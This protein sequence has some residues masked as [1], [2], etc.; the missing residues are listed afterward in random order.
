[1]ELDVL[2]QK[3]NEHRGEIEAPFVFCLWKNPDLYDD[4]KF[5]NEKEDDIIRNPDA[6]FY[7]N[8]GRALYKAGYRNF[9]HIAV[10]TFLQDKE[11]IKKQFDSYGGFKEVEEFKGLVS[12]ENVNAYFDKVARLNILDEMCKMM[13]SSFDKLEKFD[14]MTSQQIYDYFEYKLNDISITATHDVEEESLVI[15][16]AFIEECNSGDTVGISYGKQCPLLNYLTL[17]VPL[18]E[19]YM[20]AGHSGAGKSSFAFENMAIPMAQDGIK[21]AIVSNEMRSKDY[22]VMLLAHILT[23]DLNYWGLTRKQIKIGH[24]TDEQKIMIAKAQK[25]SKEKYSNLKFVKLFDNDVSKVMKYIKMNA[26]KGYQVFLWDTMKSDDS[27]DEKMFL[28]L[29][30]NSR[31]VFQLASKENIAIITTYQ[32][33]LYTVNQ[34]YLDAG[35]LANGKQIK[36]VFSEM[37]YMRTLWDDEY[38]GKKFDCRPYNLQRNAEGKYTGVKQYVEL[39][40]D[41]KYI[42]VFLDKTRNDEDKQ[43]VLYEVNGRFNSWKEIGRCNIVNEHGRY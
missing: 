13:F 20:I 28:Q 38:T 35:C 17:G 31:K 7:F 34:R 1:M 12:I 18:G 37:V 32:L 33:A 36:E 8:L 24:F 43:Q 42:V 27:L 16:D 21:V 26:K 22:K 2:L 40:P 15:D 9:D 10:Y 23:K 5:V 11:T 4:Y 30:V 41:N 6:Q 14:R 29:L 19:M 39:N 3:I 25:I